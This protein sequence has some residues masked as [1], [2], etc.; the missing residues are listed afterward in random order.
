MITSIID[1]ILIIMLVFS[2]AEITLNNITLSFFVR[3][4]KVEIAVDPTVVSYDSLDPSFAGLTIGDLIVIDNKYKDNKLIL[5]HE[6]NHVKQF[7]ALGDYFI[8]AKL[9]GLNLE[10]YPYY[11][12][13]AKCN[14]LMWQPPAWWP[15]HWHLIDLEFQIAQ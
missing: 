2:N 11:P 13:P 8:I 6:E 1:F 7:Q 15:F 4:N 5:Q 10:G 9:L 12:D 14:A 3:N